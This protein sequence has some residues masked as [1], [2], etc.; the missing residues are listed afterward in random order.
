VVRALMAADLVDEHR[1][2]VFTTVA[3]ARDSLFPAGGPPV[4]LRCLSAEQ[5]GA[6]VLT[7]YQRER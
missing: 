4:Y 3:G 2:L 7:R 1:L 5:S 6:A